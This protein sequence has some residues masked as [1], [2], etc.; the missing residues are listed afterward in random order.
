MK[1]L[2]L[3]CAARCEEGRGI[4]GRYEVA[5]AMTQCYLG[6]RL[7]PQTAHTAE[8]RYA[9]NETIT[10][11]LRPIRCRTNCRDYRGLWSQSRGM[12]LSVSFRPY[13]SKKSAGRS[14]TVYIWSI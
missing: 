1:P 10:V 11:Q 14:H 6:A 3:V 2:R 9:D 8:N 13:S 5:A 7:C 4:G 12:R